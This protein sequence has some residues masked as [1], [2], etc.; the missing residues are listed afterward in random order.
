MY[1]EIFLTQL[2]NFFNI[3]EKER[4]EMSYEAKARFLFWKV[5][6]IGLRSSI[7]TLRASQK[8]GTNISY[9]MAA[10][11]FPRQLLNFQSTLQRMQEMFQGFK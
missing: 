11:H 6:H 9:T 5:Q 8:T 10:N 2:R 1:F 3:Y 7:N 4:E